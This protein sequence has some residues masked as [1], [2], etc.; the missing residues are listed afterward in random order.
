MPFATEPRRA[1]HHE[2]EVRLAYERGREEAL[3]FPA[4]LFG[5][6]IGAL[7]VSAVVWIL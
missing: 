6:L 7:S 1:A 3:T 5:I 4:L 2:R